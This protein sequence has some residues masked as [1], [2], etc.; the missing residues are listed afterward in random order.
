MIIMNNKPSISKHNFGAQDPRNLYYE[1]A[2]T[3]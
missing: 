1:R 2:G 3:T